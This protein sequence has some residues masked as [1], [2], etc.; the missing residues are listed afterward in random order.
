[1]LITLVPYVKTESEVYINIAS[2]EGVSLGAISVNL[3][4]IIRLNLT[5]TDPS[6]VNSTREIYK[7][8]T[9]GETV[10]YVENKR[11]P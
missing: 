4:D 10:M 3:S 2:H 11:T 1:M 8:G 6:T 5:D 7:I 9:V